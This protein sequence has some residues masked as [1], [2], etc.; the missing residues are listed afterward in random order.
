MTVASTTG[1]NRIRIRHRGTVASWKVAGKWVLTSWRGALDI[2]GDG[3]VGLL[4]PIR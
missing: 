1:I 2:T 3:E 4:R